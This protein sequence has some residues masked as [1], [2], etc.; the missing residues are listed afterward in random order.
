MVPNNQLAFFSVKNT[1]LPV[2][3]ISALT[4][5]AARADQLLFY[6]LIQGFYVAT[7]NSMVT[8]PI[9]GNNHLTSENVP[10]SC[11]YLLPG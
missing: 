2:Q 7:W 9:K 10:M 3:A 11:S 4:T 5:Y 1:H 6:R 8:K